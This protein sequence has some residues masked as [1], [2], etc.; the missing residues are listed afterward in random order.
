MTAARGRQ[1]EPMIERERQDRVEVI[2]LAHGK[3]NA[4]DL[5]LL[6]ALE[7]SLASCRDAGA[8]V[9]TGQGRAFSAGVD[10]ERILD[11]DRSYVESFLVALDRLLRRLLVF[12]RPVVAALNGHALAGGW[13][14]ACAADY[15]LAAT[16]PATVGVTELAV[17]IPFP[18]S[19]L[20]TFRQ[21][22]P[23]HLTGRLTTL[24]ARVPVAEALERGMLDELV[25]PDELMPRAL[26]LAASLAPLPAE[27]L[28]TTKTQLRT[29]HLGPEGDG[30]ADIVRQWDSPE[31][32]RRI[33]DYM[34]SLARR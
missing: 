18:R 11:G 32:R 14:L 13:I 31:S 12:P 27:A 23:S 5:E 29:V 9:L 21:A 22:T 34:D 33:R 16:G 28:T 25:S 6:G 3:V 2:R 4:L 30:L 24:A 20:E 17:G 7:E 15:R 10:L 26:A 1:E 19:A 8:V